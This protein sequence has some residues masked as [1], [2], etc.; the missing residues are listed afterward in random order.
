MNYRNI[1]MRVLIVILLLCV[2]PIAAQ[3]R[4]GPKEKQIIVVFRFDDYSSRSSTDMEVKLIAAFQKHNI[5][6]TF[7][8]IP[9]VHVGDSHD[10][11][12][13]DVV[14][15]TPTKANILNNAIKTGTLE[16][17]LHG[18]SHQ[19]NHKRG[20]YTEFSGL[21]YDSQ[22]ERITKGK[23]LLE[24]ML[25]TQITIFIPPWNS[26]D[27]NTLRALEK[28]NF[29]CISS[30]RFGDAQESSPL[31][32]LPAICSLLKL[33][34]AVESARRIPEVQ[35]II[36]VLF[37]VFDFL[38]IDK[39]RGKLTYPEFVE[40]LSW[41]TSQ[42]D[43]HIASINQT[44]KTINNLSARRFIDYKKFYIKPHSLCPPFLV[45]KFYNIPTG[46]YSSQSATHNMKPKNMKIMPVVFVSIFYLATLLLS[47]AIAFFGGFI[48]F[49]RS[50]IVTSISKYGG[51]ALLVLLSIYALH[52]SVLGYFGATVITVLLGASIGVWISFLTQKTRLFKVKAGKKVDLA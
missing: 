6:C 20:G 17:A 11:S 25:D 50:E 44:T 23:N 34:D 36:V 19:T 14:P 4:S 1:W 32:F 48:I 40:L 33:R 15:L 13:Q 51:P 9:Y 28:L 39:K 27:L 2:F 10:A 8:V 18:Y 22:L 29:K 43:I 35:P 49:P 37:H 16:V 31:K 30:G 24:E 12:P 45:S 5:S 38:E 7:G 3:A 47:T 52:D 26:Y 41:L 42:K 21:A 46:I